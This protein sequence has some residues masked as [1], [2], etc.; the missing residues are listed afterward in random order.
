MTYTRSSTTTQI[1]SYTKVRERKNTTPI[2]SVSGRNLVSTDSATYGTNPNWRKQVRLNQNATTSLDGE[3]YQQRQVIREA[4]V[5]C[6]K[7]NKKA[8][9][10]T[11]TYYDV[12]HF[13][14]VSSYH[15]DSTINPSSVSTSL[16][17]N[18]AKAAF[19]KKLIKSQ[20]TFQGGVFLG[21]LREALHMLRRPA[22]SLRES[23][24]SYHR[25]A[26]KR[27]RKELTPKR[28]NRAVRDTWLEYQY[29]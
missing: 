16:A 26:K 10:P 19:L 28:K 27:A 15:M 11:G 6:M 4:D 14:L 25:T 18:L 12:Y 23:I 7:T 2:T 1:G 29:G 24:N 20:R 13:G 3:L 17:N 21:E 5:F 22:K 8:S 9:D